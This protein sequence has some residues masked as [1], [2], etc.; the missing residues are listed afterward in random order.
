MSFRQ[1][2]TSVRAGIKSG[3]YQKKTDNFSAFAQGFAPIFAQG[4]KDKKDLKMAEL[5]TIAEEKR[6]D[7]RQAAKAQDTTDA[8]DKKTQE[9]AE[10][11]W[12]EWNITDT[13]T[14]QEVLETVAAANN[15]Y[16][17][18]DKYYSDTL[19]YQRPTQGVS[20]SITTTGTTTTSAIPTSTSQAAVT[21]QAV[22][23]TDPL[24]KGEGNDNIDALYNLTKGKLSGKFANYKVSQNTIGANLDFA[25]KGGESG[26]F[27]SS[28]GLVAGRSNSGTTPMGKWQFV[29]ST[30][31]DIANRT[32][33]F[34]DLGEGF[35]NGLNT[36]FDAKAQDKI[37]AWYIN[38]TLNQAR[39]DGGNTQDNFVDRLKAR[40]EAF[41]KENPT[42]GKVFTDQ[43]ILDTVNPFIASQ[44]KTTWATGGYWFGTVDYGDAA[45]TAPAVVGDVDT[46]T[47]QIL[48]DETNVAGGFIK[49][50]AELFT[51]KL[52]IQQIA[53]DPTHPRYK[54]AVEINKIL[55]AETRGD[56]A[57]AIAG[58]T[59]TR[60]VLALEASLNVMGDSE[61]KTKV[62]E[63]LPALKLEYEILDAVGTADAATLLMKVKTRTGVAAMKAA[64]GQMA[65]GDLKTKLIAGLAELSPNINAL[66]PIAPPV[67]TGPLRDKNGKLYSM[68]YIQNLLISGTSAEKAAAK[69]HIE[70]KK[71]YDATNPDFQK[72]DTPAKVAAYLTQADFRELTIDAKQMQALN[73]H[74]AAMVKR[75]GVEGLPAITSLGSVAD[76]VTYRSLY[77]GA[78]GENAVIPQLIED[79]LQVQEEHWRVKEDRAEAVEKRAAEVPLPPYMTT[80]VTTGN[81]A[82]FTASVD[83]ALQGLPETDPNRL[84]LTDRKLHL[85]TVAAMYAD[86]DKKGLDFKLTDNYT[87]LTLKPDGNGVIRE[88]RVQLTDQGKFF[89]ITTQDFI[90]PATIEKIGPSSKRIVTALN[91]TNK[92]NQH[93]GNKLSQV[94]EDTVTLLTTAKQLDDLVRNNPEILTFVGGQA[95]A[96][97]TGLEK[98]IEA[99]SFVLGS[100]QLSSSQVEAALI[101][102]GREYAQNQ[103]STYGMASN[104]DA[105]YK[106]TAL[107]L[108]HAFS[109]AK[110]DLDSAGMALSN[111]DFNNALTINNVGKN[112]PTYSGNLKTQTNSVVE[113]ALQ[114]HA[115]LLGDPEYK[116][117]LELPLV[118]QAFEDNP[119]IMPLKE[120]LQQN[121]PE[122]YTW[123]TS[124][125]I[126][127]PPTDGTEDGGGSAGNPLI[128]FSTFMN[129]RS[130]ITER[131]V[132]Y[133]RVL[134]HED[135]KFLPN[136]FATTAKQ[137][138]GDSATP[139]QI[140]VVKTELLKQFGT[141]NS[142]EGGNQ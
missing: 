32:N 41:Q 27:D 78:Y 114:R 52:Q 99:L 49:G 10:R 88:I 82:S 131:S 90:D 108:R 60:K 17:Q 75:A 25:R 142:T 53:N 121:A 102:K 141:L 14:Q 15:N 133:Q 36:I 127:S 5:K 61:F 128:D 116:V 106:W 140:E 118:A 71:N 74:T 66:D 46:Q 97:L 21:S 18:V 70:A 120:Y 33:N 42:T 103:A 6:W 4:M 9:V 72:L 59:S 104:A 136:F 135:G 68:D 129:D 2:A 30:L 95:T 87:T 126:T 80:T 77:K 37:H 139:E 51:N 58:A 11:L 130:R 24:S 47:D 22:G 123:A 55:Q 85:T 111:M 48:S 119:T 113:K 117:T 69:E 94:K 109:F 40:Y 38:D 105:F 92:F 62:L 91:A 110:L 63:A 54:E 23:W 7:R 56:A 100:Q 101:A 73:D 96:F 19:G 122:Q 57:S 138:Y 93:F 132:Q 107:N 98:E 125:A 76:V 124:P 112:Y 65:D 137:I 31:E 13:K 84:A 26:Y 28:I 8:Y 81:I 64:I 67:E 115:L 86:A 16:L 34:T 20:T 50:P 83:A 79:A 43:E 89:D 29:H 3:A 35:E 44:D 39:K 1:A 12:A 45:Q 134:A